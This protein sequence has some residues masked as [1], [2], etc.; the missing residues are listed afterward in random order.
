MA[1]NGNFKLNDLSPE[2]LSERGKKANRASVKVRREKKEFKK[3][4]ETLLTMSV[5]GG[6]TCDIDYIKN[7]MELKGKNVTVQEAMAIKL[8]QD[9]LKGDK[10]A[11]ELVIA[12]IGEKPS[13]RLEVKDI[14]PVVFSGENELME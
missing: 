14:T 6:K 9:A 8:V 13:E 11:F 12:M 4:V 3:T 7:F 5:K 1:G 10:K 2:E